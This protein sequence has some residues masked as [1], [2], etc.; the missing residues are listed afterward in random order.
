M[1]GD[2]YFSPP[3]TDNKTFEV[4]GP[5]IFLLNR[6]QDNTTSLVPY[7]T[8]PEEETSTS[9]SYMIMMEIRS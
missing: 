9:L 4:C 1:E 2:E 8:S 7:H 3:A 6:G 5:I